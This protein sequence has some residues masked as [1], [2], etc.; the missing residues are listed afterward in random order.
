MPT[1]PKSQV[2]EEDPAVHAEREP[3]ERDEMLRKQRRSQQEIK[4]LRQEVQSMT[5]EVQRLNVELEKIRHP[6]LVVGRILDLLKDGRAVIK[7]STGPNFVVPVAD[8][9]DR[10]ELS[11][12]SR[13][14]LNQNSLTV[15][16]LLPPSRDAEVTAAQVLEAPDVTYEDLGGLEAVLQEVR[17]AVEYPL[18]DPERYARLGIKAPKGVLLSGLPGTGKTVIAKAVAHATQATFIRLVASELVQKFI[19]EGA[20]KVRE[21]FDLA[22]EKAPTIVFIDE[23]DAIAARRTDD[24]ASSNREVE[25]TLMQLLAEL[26]GFSDRGDVRFLAATNRPDI[27]DPAITRPGRFDRVIRV[28]LPTREGILEIFDI[29]TRRMALADDVDFEALVDRLGPVLTGADVQ[30]ICMEAGMHAV[31]RDGD[32]INEADFLAA[33]R[34]FESGDLSRSNATTAH[35]IYA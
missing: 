2:T 19:G 16:G 28:P 18:T 31:R 26:D 33:V 35:S 4:H 29:H 22:R 20:R 10:D 27:L 5:K 7:S 23:I 25:R 8:F 32:S 17:E 1:P 34:R 12:G 24:G 13:V 3:D 11:V 30:A 9:V 14:S 21:V 15:V 6:P